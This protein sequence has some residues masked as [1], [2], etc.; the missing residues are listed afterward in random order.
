MEKSVQSFLDTS[1]L[2]TFA[3]LVAKLERDF[4]PSEV[5]QNKEWFTLMGK[6]SQGLEEKR[7][8]A[9]LTRK[10][11]SCEVFKPNFATNKRN[12]IIQ[13][14]EKIG[15]IGIKG[16]VIMRCRKNE[17][18]Y[19]FKRKGFDIS[20]FEPYRNTTSCIHRVGPKLWAY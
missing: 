5:P 14:N 15:D 12:S 4:V 16:L 3:A 20:S 6:Q 7:A 9:D 18:R 11:N 2:Q 10:D 17:G 13:S 19:C 8:D 1:T